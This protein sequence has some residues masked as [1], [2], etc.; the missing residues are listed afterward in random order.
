MPCLTQQNESLEKPS[1]GPGSRGGKKARATGSEFEWDEARDTVLDSMR[2]ALTVDPARLW[3]QGV[4]DRCFM[5][6]F[7][8]LACKMLELPETVKTGM[9]NKLSRGGRAALELLSGPFR[10]AQGMESEVSAATF[11][12]VRE[13]KHMPAAIARL[14]QQ[15]VEKHGD[16]RL[17]AELVREI[18]RMDMPNTSMYVAPA[19][20]ARGNC[21]SRE[22]TSK[23]VDLWSQCMARTTVIIYSI[24]GHYS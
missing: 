6:L 11:M 24:M 13:H 7:L 15:M 17:G 23:F 14:C 16:A 18:G 5:L 20:H 10:L 8:R 4:P 9:H 22:S 19:F 2:L 21:Y 3:S 1:K 12:L